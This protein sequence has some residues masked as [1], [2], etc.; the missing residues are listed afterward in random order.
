MSENTELAKRCALKWYELTPELAREL[1][2]EEAVYENRCDQGPTIVGPDA[3]YAILDAYRNMCDRFECQLLNIA[4]NGDVVLLEREEMT[5]LKNGRTVHL[6]VMASFRIRDG[7][8]D[9]WREYWDLALLTNQLMLGESAE[10]VA[11]R[12]A[13]YQAQSAEPAS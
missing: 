9:R 10:E 11:D 6:P 3:I 8:I 12:Y 2:A 4:E 1:F 7:K 5:Y 13:N